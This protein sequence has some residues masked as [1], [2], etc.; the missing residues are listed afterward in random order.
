M[1]R[2]IKYVASNARSLCVDIGALFKK[3]GNSI[4]D[5]MHLYF[6]LSFQ[7]NTLLPV[8][9]VMAM[10]GLK[11]LMQTFDLFLFERYQS[12][13]GG[14]S[15]SAAI[16]I[17]LF[18]LCQAMFFNLFDCNFFFFHFFSLRYYFSIFRKNFINSY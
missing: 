14:T 4:L 2:V 16:Q 1:H 8:Y 3:L 12:I 11:G 15:Q 6:S 10:A 13:I 7:M 17:T 5:I 18:V 9:G